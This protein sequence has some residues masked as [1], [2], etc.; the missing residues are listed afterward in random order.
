MK[1]PPKYVKRAK[2]WCVTELGTVEK[3]K[4][5]TKRVQKIQWFSSELEANQFFKQ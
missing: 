4:N 3:V 1:L 5:T 2:C